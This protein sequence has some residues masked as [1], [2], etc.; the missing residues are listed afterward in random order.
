MGRNH[1]G[2][3][4]HK[5]CSM[6][7]DCRGAWAK[8]IDK[9][10]ELREQLH[11]AAPSQVIQAVQADAYGSMLWRLDSEAAEQ[12]FKSWNTFVKLVFDI[13]MSTFTYLVE[14]Y[15]ASRHTSLRSS[16]GIQDLLG[17]S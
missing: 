14:G 15:F 10:V 1:L 8:F 5:L 2:H 17:T 16:L 13:P 11:F 6:N 9:C 3:K 4:L 7:K 12:Y